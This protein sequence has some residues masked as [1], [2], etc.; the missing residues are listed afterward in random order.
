MTNTFAV[1]G[2]REFVQCLNLGSS[3]WIT[4]STVGCSKD[5]VKV[6]DSMNL[7]LSIARV[8][9]TKS[10]A[11]TLQYIKVQQQC[12]T[13][14]CGL[15]G[16]ANACAICHGLDAFS[17]QYN[18]QELRN[19]LIKSLESNILSPFPSRKR[20]QA[21]VMGNISYTN[22]KVRVYCLCQIPDNGTKMIQCCAYKEWYHLN[23]IQVPTKSLKNPMDIWNC[24]NCKSH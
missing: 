10:E 19:H 21:V 1:Q 16:I 20:Y 3:H 7:L 11:F 24:Y 9:Y 6:Y 5:V 15:I 23:C 22:Q 8:L 13:S 18:Q 17:L 2:H 4:I 14:D 12:G